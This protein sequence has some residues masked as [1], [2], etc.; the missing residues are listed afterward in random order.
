MRTEYAQLKAYSTEVVADGKEYD[1]RGEEI[2]D[3]PEGQYSVSEYQYR[4]FTNSEQVKADDALSAAK[5]YW[6]EHIGGSYKIM[7]HVE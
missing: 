1:R 5:A 3:L 7:A 2:G 4:Q 6:R